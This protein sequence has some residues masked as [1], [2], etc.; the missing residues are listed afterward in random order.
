MGS[1]ESLLTVANPAA[2]DYTV[3]VGTRNLWVSDI[4]YTNPDASYDLEVTARVAIDLP[5]DNGVQTGHLVDQQIDYYRLTVPD[6]IA[7]FPVSGL[8]IGSSVTNGSVG[9]YLAKGG[10]PNISG[11]PTLSVTSPFVVVAPPYL[12]PG[13]WY[14]AVQGTGITD[15]TVTSQLISSAPGHHSRSWSMP[16]ADGSFTP[17]YDGGQVDLLPAPLFGDSGVLSP[18][19]QGICTKVDNPS[20]HDQGVDLAQDDWHFYRVTVPTNNG[21]MLRTMVEALSGNPELYLRNGSAPSMFHAD[22]VT[23]PNSWPQAYDRA[24]TTAGT[25]YGNW[26][27]LDRRTELQLTPGEWWLG[28]R[29]VGSNVRYRLKLSAGNVRSASGPVDTA[30][31]FQDFPLSGGSVVGQT[32]AAGDMRFYRVTIPPSD[33]T[34]ATSTPLSWNLTLQQQVGDVRVFIRDS[35]PPGNGT[36]GNNNN[37]A[38]NSAD[39]YYNHMRD[40]R[41]DNSGLSPDPYV[42]ID[43]P[44]TH[45]LT[46][47]PLRPGATYFVGVHALTDTMFDLS[48]GVGTDRLKLDGVVPFAGGNIVT[49]LPAGGQRLYRIDVPADAIY[50]HHTALHDAGVKL[51]LAQGTVPPVDA[52]QSHWSSCYSWDNTNCQT[53]SSFNKYLFETTTLNNYPWQPGNSYYLLVVN[54]TAGDL[55]FTFTMDGRTS[56]SQLTVSV[57]GN[58]T[59]VIR[60]NWNTTD[61]IACS[62][63]SCSKQFVPFTQV[64]LWP[65]LAPGST[66]D[67]WGGDCAGQGWYCTLSMDTPHTVTAAL[68]DTS[69]PTVSAAPVGGLYH[70]PPSVTLAANEPGMIYYTLD[71]SDPRSSVT[72]AK[73]TAPLSIATATTVSFYAIDN[74][75]NSGD[76]VVEQ[77]SVEPLTTLIPGAGIYRAP[78]GVVMNASEP[79]TIRYTMDGSDPRTS[80]TATVYSSP[81]AIT[82]D[83]TVRYYAEDGAGNKEPVKAATYTFTGPITEIPSQG[84]KLWLRADSGVIS[85]QGTITSWYDLSG[86]GNNANGTGASIVDNELNGQPMVRFNGNQFYSVAPFK[87]VNPYTIFAV[88]R[89]DGVQKA[90]LVSSVDTNWLLGYWM[91]YENQFY[92]EGWVNQPAIPATDLPTLYAASGSGTLS[93]L[94]MN[95]VKQAENGNGVAAPGIL[96]LGGSGIYGEY[97]DGKIA[98]IIVYDSVLSD[99]QRQ[100]VVNYLTTRYDLK[101]DLTVALAGT[102]TG[103]VTSN[104]AGI[105]CTTGSCS[106]PFAAGST[107]TLSATASGNSVFGGWT[108]ACSGTGSCTVTLDA[109]KTV[110]AVFDPPPTPQSGMLLYY[111]FD[112]SATDLSG[113]GR[114]GLQTGTTTASDKWGGAGKAL[115][116]NGSGD[117]VAAPAFDL[118][119][120]FSVT[121]WVNANDINQNWQRLFDFGNGAGMDN[122]Y[123]AWVNGQM[124]FNAAN[125]GSAQQIT[126]TGQFPQQ[127]WVHVA[128]THDGMTGTIY[129]NGEVKAS[130]PLPFISPLSRTN[131][132]IARSNWDGDPSFNGLLDDFRV[133]GR[134]LT[135]S[136][137]NTLAASVPPSVLPLTVSLQGVPGYDKVAIEPGGVSC[138]AAACSVVFAPGTVVT[139]T[140]QP[141]TGSSFAGWSGDC[142]GTST[143]CSVTMSDVRSV[144]AAFTDPLPASGL[145]LWLRS[146]LGVTAGQ[147]GAVSAWQDQSG[148]GYHLSMA[149]PTRQPQLL[150]SGPFATPTLAFDGQDDYLQTSAAVPLI[151]TEQLSAF[152]VT[153]PGTSQQ[154]Y[155]DI[156]DYNHASG[157]NFVIQQDDTIT[158]SYVGGQKLDPNLF[159]IFGFHYTNGVGG[160]T[161]VNSGS[162]LPIPWTTTSFVEPN[163]LTLGNKSNNAYNRPYN[164]AISEVIVYNR[165]LSATERIGVEAYLKTRYGI[166]AYQ[167]TVSVPGGNGTVT[168]PS[169][170]NHGTDIVCTVTPNP[171]YQLTAFTDNS[172]DKLASVSGGNY[173]ISGVAGD[174][175]IVAAFSDNQKPTVTAFTLPATATTATVGITTFTATDNVAV[176]GYL[177]T[178]TTTV[179]SAGAAGW[180]TAKPTSYT[181][182]GIPD[183][184]ATAKTLYAWA[185][186]AAGNVSTSASATV[187]ITLPDITKPMVTAF[188]LPATSATATVGITTF[189]ATDNLAVTGYLVTETSAAPSAGAAGW[190]AAKPTQY[191]FTN[192]P[193]AVATAKTLYAWARDAAGN[194]SAGVSTT[195]TITLP[196]ITKPAVTAFT[197]PATSATATVGITT[198]AATDNVAVT[199]YLVTETSAAP[200]AGAAGWTIAKPTSYTFS[201]VPDG[202]ATA[203]TLYAWAKDAAGNVSASA[204]A[205]VAITL[206][207]VT[208][209]TVES[210][211]LPALVNTLTVTGLTITASDNVAVTGYLLSESVSVPSLSAA[212]WTTSK[213]TAFTF[214]T[215]GGKTLYLFV[216]DGAGNISAPQGATVTIDI[217]PPSLVL[218]T[219]ANGKATNASP[220][221]V[222]GTVKDNLAVSSLT[223]NGIAITFKPADGSFSHAVTLVA[224]ANVITTI[225]TDSAGNT[226]T[227]VRTIKFDQVPPKLTVTTPADNSATSQL[228]STISGSVDENC[229]VVVTSTLD[230]AKNATMNGNSFTSSVKLQQGLNTVD[231]TAAD[232]A[233]N[234]TSAKRTIIYDPLKPSLTVTSPATDVTV[235]DG[236]VIISGTADGT[237]SAIDDLVITA[238]G[239]E[240]HPPLSGGSFSQQISLGDEKLYPI[241]VTATDLAGNSTS[242][243]RNVNS[244]KGTIVINGGALYT[245]SS[246][247]T[248]SLGYYPSAPL[249][250]FY[251]DGKGWSKA[252]PFAPTKLI[253][254]SRGDGLKTV[255]VRFLAEDGSTLGEYADTITLDTVVPSGTLLINGGAPFTNSRTVNLEIGAQDSTSGMSKLCVR[256]DKLPCAESE[257]VPYVTAMSYNIVSPEDGKKTVYV[258]LRDLAGK[259][260][261][262]LKGSITLDTLA[263]VGSIVINGGKAITVTPLVALKLKA[264]KAAEMQLSLDGVS[265]GPWEKYTGSKKVTLPGGGGEKTVKVRFRDLAGNESPEYQDS[266]ILQ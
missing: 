142:S 247:V 154:Q 190:S 52:S 62:S 258:T 159:S 99:L 221:N 265:W 163:V 7:G 165:M 47:P 167:V 174:H 16:A 50:W 220:L 239:K 22:N 151:G 86:N 199:G 92:A 147:D 250:Q 231:I 53:D 11:Q 255:T 229:T 180:T 28:V 40:W 30:G 170:V 145:R 226:T 132:F 136:E 37:Q 152:V 204:S 244:I 140:A 264:L 77:Y 18:D 83:T 34:L 166:E 148:N 261:K 42:V 249:M 169:P 113:F 94:F 155:A 141:G 162:Q 4:G 201:G 228:L 70:A 9:L 127:Q 257:F 215:A 251:F 135:M 5:S 115:S 2:G 191:T 124:M 186:D 208:K 88:T 68:S 205:S 49:S 72:R 175:A 8:K 200:A 110:T 56:M 118:G 235:H 103:F 21:G 33:T 242:V 232:L 84:I 266:I 206:P 197:L 25:M 116:F 188:T 123:V 74:G 130:G 189:T 73:Y 106:A 38:P 23:E 219:L 107:V 66:F 238:D 64:T 69:I 263:P 75:G 234:S 133:Y 65:D 241:T 79:A 12:A 100:E 61:D 144:T 6:S 223:I 119:G 48:S 230:G 254:L 43:N 91:G 121:A 55:P 193:E 39:Y 134:V 41:G 13:V 71:G 85:D 164:G 252:E 202:V 149:D 153:R 63:G 150:S 236:S 156:L 259:T 207:D 46:T 89:Q 129:W 36:D 243:T 67:S 194:V 10:L 58:G 117:H 181:F 161:Y 19:G 222:S 177:V 29:A 262:P 95:G 125:G 184:I 87:V 196:D 146:D 210:F 158:N 109:L 245:V 183:G 139:L 101:R 137:V 78:Q 80:P 104:P 32:L 112:G 176:T 253:T 216:R 31:Y 246:K 160:S 213:P 211:T 171:G 51:F 227:D 120:A 14:L 57:S 126:T 44:G 108:G 54:T 27:T 195:V 102:G 224:G 15:Y 233:G 240:Y 138:K 59:G 172:T 173:T 212:G 90:R 93:T 218:S 157:V 168:C 82:T 131:Q 217:T 198:L 179:P 114:N 237:I 98:E 122:L 17:C 143:S 187:T 182:S 26:A 209:P 81:V 203:K 178:E 20:T 128:V 45:T 24:Q 260:S 248:V 214:A 1:N 105:S 76:V 97:S 111:P 225:A 60:S 3:V 35:I 256:E 96:T 185:K 192:I